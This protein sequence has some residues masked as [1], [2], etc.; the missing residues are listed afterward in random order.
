M[1]PKA[2][3]KPQAPSR[4]SHTAPRAVLPAGRASHPAP[5]AHP[6]GPNLSTGASAHPMA[7]APAPVAAVNPMFESVFND[8]N[9]DA[10]DSYNS[11]IA[12]DREGEQR[13][14]SDYGFTPQYGADGSVDY[15]AT[16]AHGVDPNNPFSKMAL[17]SR[18]YQ[19]QQKSTTNGY[20]AQGQLFS[21]AVQNQRSADQFTNDQQT[22]ATKQAFSDAI[23]NF[24][25]NR[26]TAGDTKAS[27]LRTAATT[28]RNSYLGA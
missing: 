19:N 8:S 9:S 17:L 28:R 22:A 7:A 6:V 15:N 25:Q 18:A 11:T 23:N 4:P 1:I 27:A 13:A 12:G 10:N 16:M 21:G 2:K 3:V 26:R 14:G 20:A 5:V 24:T